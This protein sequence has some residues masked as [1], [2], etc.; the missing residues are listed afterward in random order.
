MDSLK[1]DGRPGQQHNVRWPLG[2]QGSPNSGVST[3][4]SMDPFWPATRFVNKML[5]E[6]SYVHLFTYSSDF[7]LQGQNRVVVTET[8]WAAKPKILSG[9]LQ[10][11][12]LLTPCWWPL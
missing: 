2:G 1:P 7:K 12:G 11:K 6:H 9:P 3:L 8:V 5:L 4:L 10:K